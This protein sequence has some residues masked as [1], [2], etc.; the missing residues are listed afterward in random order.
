MRKESFTYDIKSS[1]LTLQGLESIIDVFESIAKEENQASK[2]YHREPDF[3]FSL[4]N[5][6]ECTED[7]KSDFLNKF[8]ECN[9]PNLKT[10]TLVYYGSATSLRLSFDRFIQDSISLKI[11]T[12]DRK[13]Y[14]YYKDR[15]LQLL[16]KGNWNWFFH[17]Y[18]ALFVIH[19]ISIVFVFLFFKIVILH[20]ANTPLYVYFIPSALWLVLASWPARIYPKLILEGEI[21]FGRSIRLDIWKIFIAIA[22][23]V[24]IPL[25]IDRLK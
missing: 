20:G 5:G 2:S 18:P 21:Q 3:S 24:A 11:E 7:N 15:L 19:F 1:N 17:S 10:L 6:Y 13:D 25:I 4:K 16:G 8:R 14:A 22:T 23:L 9:I 12:S